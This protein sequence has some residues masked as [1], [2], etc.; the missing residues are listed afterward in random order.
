MKLK[1]KKVRFLTGRPV[2]MINEK[3]AEKMSLHVGERVSITKGGK[4]MISIVDI[5][6]KILER[7]E[8]AVSE[9]II[10]S[11][12][13]KNKDIVE[14]KIAERPHSINLIKKKLK[15]ELLNK[16]EIEEIIN[17]IA[18]N[19]LTEVETAFFVSAVYD[20]GMSLNEIKNSYFGK[21]FRFADT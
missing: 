3:T 6:E 14:V 9:E 13:L 17:N 18:N 16:K 12:W 8:I 20:R 5:V 15:G 4:R 21:P 19:S 2:C 10:N 11:L 7:N 1:I